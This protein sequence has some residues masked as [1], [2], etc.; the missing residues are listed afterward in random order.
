MR[1]L[2]SDPPQEIVVV[3][4]VFRF[5]SN[6]GYRLRA[7]Q[8]DPQFEALAAYHNSDGG[9]THLAKWATSRYLDAW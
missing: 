9:F 7:K 2:V 1:K 4:E 6:K 3:A 5:D 8:S